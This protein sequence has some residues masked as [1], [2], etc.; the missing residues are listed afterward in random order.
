MSSTLGH[1]LDLPKSIDQRARER[2]VSSFRA[3]IL[4]D[5]AG[6]LRDDYEANVAPELGVPQGGVEVHRALL[7]R[8]SFARYSSLRCAAQEMVWR[9]V[10]EEVEGAADHLHGAFRKVTETPKGS[11]KLDPALKLPRYY[12]RVDVHLMPGNYQGRGEV[13]DLAPGAIYDN[14]FNV[15]A[16]G[17]M[18]RQHND[19]GMSMANF[20]RLRF[21]QLEPRS[22]V[23]VGCTIGH[24]TLPWKQV[25]PAA[26]VHG[27]DASAA[28]L[29]YAHGRAESLQVAVNFQQ[30]LA[31]ALPFA[32][33]S[34]D[35]VFSSMFLHELPPEEIRAFLKEAHRVL[36]PGGIMLHMELPPNGALA[37][38]D[39]FY[40]DWDSY[41][42]NEPHYKEFRDLDYQT[43]CVEAG[44]GAEDYFQSVMPRYTYVSEQDF[45]RVIGLDAKFDSDTGRLSDSIQWFGFGAV[46]Q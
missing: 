9:S 18:G 21:P 26:V 15:F 28:C 32:E 25:F 39:A 20:A 24:N 19:I 30:G 37:P 27:I 22:I 10:I 23:D 11:L 1:G 33:G 36:R 38:F 42:N 7:G 41:Y 34:L 2:F 3:Y 14:G 40:L 45:S 13:D 46:R 31:S 12:D 5:L 16:F 8:E 35:V 4:N 17:A 6:Q 44:F 29:R 43:L